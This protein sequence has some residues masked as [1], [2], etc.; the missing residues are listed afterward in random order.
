MFAVVTLVTLA[1][2]IG[3][4]TAIFS[5]LEGVLLKPLPYPNAEQLIAIDHRAPGVNLEHAGQA[6][7]LHFIESEQNRTLQST[8]MW[9]GNSE[10]VTGTGEPQ[11]EEGVDV[12]QGMLPTLGARPLVGRLF[13]SQDDAPGAPRTVILSYAYWQKRYGGERS[14]IGKTIIGDGDQFEII[15]VL[16]KDFQFLD[17]TP[18]LFMPMRLDRAKTNLGNFSYQAIAR[19]KPG[20]SLAQ[21]NADLAR[22]I[23]V[24]IDTFPPFPGYS[25]EMFQQVGLA[26]NCVALKDSVV[27]DVGKTLWILMATIGIVLIIACANVANLLLVRTEGRQQELAIRAALG[28][29]SGRIARELFAESLLLGVFG[30]VLGLGLAYGAIRWLVAMAPS[31]L[32]RLSEISIDTPVMLF[33]LLV[34]LLSGLFFG[35]IP[36]LKYAGPRLATTLRAGGRSLSHSKERHRARSTLVVVQVGLA[37]LLLIGSGLMIRTFQTLRNVQPGFTNPEKLLAVNL[38]VPDSQ[39]KDPLQAIRMKQEILD[40]VQSMPGVES[41]AYS[42]FVPMDGSGWHDP[43]FA[44]DHVYADRKI[45]PLRRFR[46]VSPGLLKTMGNRLIAG[47]DFTWTD[48][49]DMRPVAL[50]SENLAREL[51]HDPAAAIGKRIH[52]NPS[53]KLR[54]IVGVVNDERDDGV[55]QDAPGV[56][57]WPLI[58]ADFSGNKLFAE[59]GGALMVRSNRTG[60]SGFVQD[61]S[62]TVWSINPALPLANVRTMREIYDKS[63]ARTSFALVMLGLAGAM[64]LLLGVVGIYG[65]ISYSVSQRTREI[66]I[67]M[68]LGSP[69]MEVTR[70]FLWHGLRLA[71]IGVGCGLIAAVATTRL[72]ASMLFHVSPLDPVT[73]LGVSGGLVAAAALASFL[74][75][76]RATRVD[77]V[78]ALRAE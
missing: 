24:A 47:R 41:A 46:M 13:T 23:P 71:A 75:A 12:T 33:A 57:Y 64:A 7:F 51:W 50:V 9:Q 61:L 62:R 59:R 76:L 5:V 48:V 30:G 40:K 43:I 70:M 1:I 22:L 35:A 55:N 20:V 6:P 67:R 54:E 15:G 38:Y 73:Y 27:G 36:V 72:M 78:D 58:M 37:M 17:R 44:E 56:A 63:L 77:P 14:A 21:A 60:S 28:A 66:G 3:A 45:P 19:L 74:P 4:N 32:P 34:S 2:G 52:E 8:G 68:A 49:Y 16:P 25:K 42:S 26:P 53:A 65:V 11:Q 29:G 18:A 31:H 39:V 10:A 69:Q